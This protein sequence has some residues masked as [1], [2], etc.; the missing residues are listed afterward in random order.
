M[1]AKQICVYQDGLCY[2]ELPL[3]STTK[4]RYANLF[5]VMCL[6]CIQCGKVNDKPGDKSGIIA[7]LTADCRVA[8]MKYDG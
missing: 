6:I 2:E 8:V 7:P 5:I 3:T 1:K 4:Q